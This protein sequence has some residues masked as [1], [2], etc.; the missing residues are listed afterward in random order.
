MTDYITKVKFQ[1]DCGATVNGIPRKLI[2]WDKTRVEPQGKYRTTIRNCKNRKEYGVEF[3]EL[4]REG[5]YTT[6]WTCNFH[7]NGTNHC[8][9][10]KHQCTGR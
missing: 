2:M 5:L 8:Q 7:S 4:C 9:L 6:P 3:I 10:R 1:V